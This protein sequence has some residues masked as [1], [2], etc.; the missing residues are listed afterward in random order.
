MKPL[1]GITASMEV[2]K[3]GHNISHANVDAITRAGGIPVVLPNILEE[4]NIE[5]L[6]NKIDGLY[7]TGGA[8]IDPTLFGEEPHKDLGGVTPTRDYFELTMTKKILD[9]G[10]P[11]MGVCRGS[12]ILNV[13]AGGTL[14]QDIHAQT[15]KA[16][17]QHA[18]K[19]PRSHGSHF[20]E[21]EEGSLLHRLTGV[22]KHKINSYHH[23]AAKDVADGFQVSGRASD[24]IVEAIEKKDHPFVLGVQWH[25]ELMLV[26]DDEASMKIF[27]GFI[28]ACKK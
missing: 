14:Y 20:V 19:A 4:D 28:E 15:D 3:K 23:Q 25:P 24:G 21:I 16:L 22:E 12:Q 8:D 9:K 1:I 18:Q 11:F 7:V 17:L 26:E 13:A 2:G 6:A 10:K 27:K 5:E